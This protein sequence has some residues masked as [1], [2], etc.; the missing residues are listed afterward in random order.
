MKEVENPFKLVN[1]KECPINNKVIGDYSRIS[2]KLTYDLF[3]KV[4]YSN[5]NFYALLKEKYIDKGYLPKKYEKRIR[6]RA[7]AYMAFSPDYNDHKHTEIENGR[8][9]QAIVEHS[10]NEIMKE[11]YFG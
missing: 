7:M 8:I 2:N 9:K 3:G 6:T 5:G 4:L 10:R 1:W 11:Y